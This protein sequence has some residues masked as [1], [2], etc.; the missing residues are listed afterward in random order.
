[1]KR[2]LRYLPILS[3][4]LGWVFVQPLSAQDTSAVRKAARK[5]ERD[6]VWANIARN[7]IPSL[8][9]EKGKFKAS[10]NLYMDAY[11]TWDLGQPKNKNR[12]YFYSSQRHNEFMLNLGMLDAQASYADRIRARLALGYGSYFRYNYSAEPAE[13]R[14]LFEANAGVRLAKNFWVDGGIIGSPFGY[15]S[16]L[17]MQQI[18]YT[19]SLSADNTPY[20]LTGAKLTYTPNDQVTLVG[21]IING[22][23]TIQSTKTTPSGAWQVQYKPKGN[24]LLNYSGYFGDERTNDTLPRRWRIFNDFYAYATPTEKLTLLG[25]FDFGFQKSRAV[26]NNDD[27]QMWST[28][29]FCA[30]Y[31][32]TRVVALAARGEYYMDKGQ[33]N[34]TTIDGTKGFFAYGGSVNLDISPIQNALLR[35]EVRSLGSPDKI[36]FAP[37]DGRRNW[38]TAFTVSLAVSL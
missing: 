13:Y 21:Y 25:L 29:N 19:R 27:W 11:Y 38:M 32:F 5:A 20:F 17:S 22:W 28:V 10:L 8:S 9:I 34:I 37:K 2:F 15:E 30:K 14:F 6:S 4:L 33:A 16:A 7:G 31:Q 24:V 1:M 26:T 18:N 35:F 3:L 23:Q 36:F 12:P